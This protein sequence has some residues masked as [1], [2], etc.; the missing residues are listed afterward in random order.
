VREALEDLEALLDAV[1]VRDY[2]QVLLRGSAWMLEETALVRL[3]DRLMNQGTSLG[4]FVRGRIYRGVTTGL[5]EAFVIDEAKRHELIAADPRSAEL[6]KPWLRGRDIK[7]WHPRWA[8]LFCIH[9]PWSLDID[10]YPEVARHLEGFRESLS[11]RPE[12]RA[13]IFPWWAMSRWA[14]DYYPEFERPKVVWAKTANVP[15]FAFDPDRH[16]LGNTAHFIPDAEPWLAAVLNSSIHHFLYRMSINVLRGGYIEL[17]PD[18][19]MP[20]PVPEL[21]LVDQQRLNE[22]ITEGGEGPPL[23]TGEEIVAASFRLAKADL[24]LIEGWLAE[25]APELD[26]SSPDSDE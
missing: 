15:T 13:G 10:G 23:D 22:V 21:A 6:I 16:W 25:R 26:E 1:A 14:A 2:R 11:H 8:G 18:R 17:T 20:F 5:N 12:V 3:F 4:D 19:I 24:H 9:V 7:R